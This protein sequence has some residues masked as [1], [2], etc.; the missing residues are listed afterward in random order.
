M[1]V[2]LRIEHTKAVLF[3]L[4]DETSTRVAVGKQPHPWILWYV[5]LVDKENPEN[6]LARASPPF[7]FSS[8]NRLAA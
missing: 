1:A 4:F 7:P 5:R 6:P 8:Q 2:E 3:E